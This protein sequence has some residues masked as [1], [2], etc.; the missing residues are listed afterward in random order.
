[1]WTKRDDRGDGPVLG[2]VGSY[3]LRGEH[4]DVVEALGPTMLAGALLA[5]TEGRCGRRPQAEP[6]SEPA[7]PNTS[8]A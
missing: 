4:I 8:R 3:E 1:M 2:T 5:I 6:A 7:V